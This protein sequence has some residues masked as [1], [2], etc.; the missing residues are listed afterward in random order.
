MVD[1]QGTPEVVSGDIWGGSTALPGARATRRCMAESRGGR[2]PLVGMQIGLCTF[3]VLLFLPLWDS[4]IESSPSAAWTD[5]LSWSCRISEA[6][7]VP[8]QPARAFVCGLAGRAWLGQELARWYTAYAARR[9]CCNL[10]YHFHPMIHTKSILWPPA[11]RCRQ[12]WKFASARGKGMRR[13]ADK[14]LIR[15]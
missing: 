2:R 11:A 4:L 8:L 10:S 5:R 3:G 7:I 12:T 9:Y 14:R 6:T 1:G 15:R 13:R